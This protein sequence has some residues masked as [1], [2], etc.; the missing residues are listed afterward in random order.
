M[1]P[2][3][4]NE[5]KS[6]HYLIVRD[7]PQLYIN[8]LYLLI[9]SIIVPP[10]SF[11]TWNPSSLDELSLQDHII[12]SVPMAVPVKSVGAVIAAKDKE[13]QQNKNVEINKTG[14]MVW[15]KSLKKVFKIAL[16]KDLL[17]INYK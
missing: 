14:K 10:V 9:N 1:N 16:L 2:R 17:F 15:R 6:S 5:L 13:K 4:L 3:T 8:M 12:V 7:K 11:F